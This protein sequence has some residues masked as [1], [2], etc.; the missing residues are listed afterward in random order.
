MAA[1]NVLFSTTVAVLLSA[2]AMVVLEPSVEGARQF[3]G[4][5]YVPSYIQRG[6]RV[7]QHYDD[8]T[9]RLHAYYESLLADEINSDKTAIRHFFI[10][11]LHRGYLCLHVNNQPGRRDTK[12]P[13]T[14]LTRF[15]TMSTKELSDSKDID[16]NR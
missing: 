15:L 10:G 8:Y 7:Q 12:Q 1:L 2:A 4:S 13:N 3:P 9:K 5:P 14:C 6:N 11:Y 16:G